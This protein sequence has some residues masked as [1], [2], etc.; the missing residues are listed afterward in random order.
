MKYA[1]VAVE[2]TTFSFDKEFDY[3]IPPELEKSALKG[4]RVTVPFGNGNKKRLGFIFDIK[5][6]SDG[7]RL[8][9]ILEVT[10]KSPLL[11]HE[12]IELARWIKDRTFCT[13]Y[14][15]AKAM[16][17]SGINNRIVVSYAANPECNQDTIS[18]LNDVE[19]EIFD[20]LVNR[21]VF[22]K[23]ENI[24][25]SL[26]IKTDLSI[27][28][29]LAK[30]DVLL[31][32]T[33][34]V[35]NLGDLT[36][37][38]LRALPYE[39]N[40][41]LT[42]K[43]SEMLEVLRDMGSASVKELCYFTGFTSAVADSL[44]KKGLAE[45]YEQETFSLPDFCNQKCDTTP[46]SL[47]DEQQKAYD[48]LSEQIDAGKASVSLLYGVT[49][50]GKTSVYMSVIDR[51]I[52]DGKAVIVMVPEIGLTPQ[53]LSLF[54]RRYGNKVAVFHSALSMRERL[55]HWK[56]VK[57]GEAK[58][59]IGTRSAVFAPAEDV[60]LIIVDE[61]Q[62][63]TYKSEQTPRYNAIDVAKFRAAYNKCLL[64]LASATPSVES[65]ASAVNG[66]YELCTLTRRYGNAVLPEVIT[67]DMRTEPKAFSSKAISQTLYNYLKENLE[68]KKQS[69]L[70]INRRGF[71]TF[72][73]CDACGDV[74]SCPHCSI[75]MTYHM[76]NRRLMCHYCGY[77]VPMSEICPS[78][79]ESS[80][81]FSGFGTQ[82]IEDE[83][84]VLFPEARIIR[85]DTDSTS[86]KNSHERVLESFSKG[87]YD[88]LI[89]TQM[90]AKG[91]NFPN[92]TLVGVVS[93]DQQLYN[94]DFRSLE[95]TFSLL[96]Q[97]VGRSGRGEHKGI[98]I[99][100][101]LTPENEIIRLA[102]KQDYDEFFET[103]IRLRKALIYPPY[104]DI[105]VIGFV[106]ESETAAV[107]ASNDVLELIKKL[108]NDEFKGE[109]LI[110][111][112]PMPSRVAKVN[113]KYRY[114]LIIKCRN[115]VRFRNL[116]SK[117]LVTTGTDSRYSNVTVYADI[118][119][120]STI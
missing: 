100:Q 48:K 64:L 81:R 8:K 74:I 63:H 76:A 58:I 117:I 51:V 83:L 26:K 61:E 87:E 84:A 113:E 22:V 118:N 115:S 70:L 14:E 23:G 109:K 99:I 107:N 85:M 16:L 96:T 32:N 120:D 12:M 95:K 38:M 29:S 49:G 28:E 97:V 110:T 56:R 27:I 60:G 15:A 21:A 4:C 36:V 93:V 92:V 53:T 62:E 86:G 6:S 89:G 18:K 39:A 19:R 40:L 55:E 73:S 91:L 24:F 47:T 78:C 44:V 57:K 98:A 116:I 1:K 67:V 68:N 3:I 34:A 119:P 52:N 106:S 41:K 20:Y 7:K 66:K 77:S 10:D 90:V 25:K 103:E 69:I 13:F 46:V 108:L 9:K 37:K 33:D 17:P 94:D 42:S 79:G 11:S 43:Q 105:C 65:F 82:K 35:R 54:A 50:S 75:S 59:I 101:T 114:R 45:Y 2:S 112:G 102:A 111:L 71:N 104:C 5:D 88:I 31:T 80:V 72:V 30:K